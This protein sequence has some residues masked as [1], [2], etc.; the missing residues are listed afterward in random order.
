MSLRLY[1]RTYVYVPEIKQLT[2]MQPDAMALLLVTTGTGLV[3]NISLTSNKSLY[4]SQIQFPCMLLTTFN[5][6]HR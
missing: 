5:K 2:S 1:L 6:T 4:S 3:S